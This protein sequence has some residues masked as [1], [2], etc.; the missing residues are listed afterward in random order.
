MKK[1][2]R[3]FLERLGFEIDVK[4]DYPE[5]KRRKEVGGYCKKVRFCNLEKE[6]VNALECFS[7]RLN[8]LPFYKR[9]PLSKKIE[10]LEECDKFIKT[11]YTPNNFYFYELDRIDI[12]TLLSSFRDD[13]IGD[14]PQK[15][16]NMFSVAIA[17][18]PVRVSL[19]EEAYVEFIVDSDY[20][21]VLLDVTSVLD[22]IYKNNKFRY[23]GLREYRPL[24][25]LFNFWDLVKE[26]SLYFKKQTFYESYAKYSYERPCYL[27]K[28]K[29]WDF[30]KNAKTGKTETY[31]V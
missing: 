18:K 26:D 31:L 19:S 13:L 22:N 20:K 27:K 4:P 25:G 2:P 29:H 23:A 5:K 12:L 1:F 11:C 30:R 9:F 15:A 17:E 8:P 24:Y 7:H 10:V 6:R 14:T 3:E 21:N 28:N 16:Y